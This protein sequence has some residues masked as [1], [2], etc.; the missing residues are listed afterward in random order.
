MGGCD[1]KKSLTV[2]VL[3]SA[4]SETPSADYSVIK[5]EL[6]NYSKELSLKTEY[7]FLSK[8]DV[9]SEGNLNDKIAALKKIGVTATAISIHDESSLNKV[10]ENL[11]GIKAKK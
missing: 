11:N 1:C 2:V 10:K 8:S 3:I 4:E 9:I 5:K 7:V 6:A